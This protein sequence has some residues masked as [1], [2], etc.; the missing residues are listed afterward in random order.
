MVAKGSDG[1]H[2]HIYSFLKELLAKA[3]E[4]S[5]NETDSASLSRLAIALA[6]GILD[7]SRSLESAEDQERRSALSQLLDA[8]ESQL[9]STALTD[10]VHR[11]A[12]PSAAVRVLKDLLNRT[13]GGKN[14][15]AVDR[16]QLRAARMFGSVVPKLTQRA[17]IHR[18]VEEASPYLWS[19]R[20]DALAQSLS[21]AHARGLSV[22]L[23][24]LGEEVLGQ[25]EANARLEAYQSLASRS[26]IDA[27][28]LK[29]SAIE[30][31]LELRCLER[32]VAALYGRVGLVIEAGG[33]RKGGPPLLYFDMETYHDLPV[34][35]A[36]MERL[37]REAP[38]SARLGIAIQAYIPESLTAVRRL[39]AES[40]ERVKNGGVPL[41]IRLVKGAN[42][43]M[44]TVLASQ[45]RLAVPIFPA[46]DQVDAHFKRVLRKAACEAERGH[47]SLGVGSHNLFD[48]A[49]AILVREVISKNAVLEIEMLQGMAGTVGLV[50]SELTGRLLIYAPC[51]E[52][53]SFSSAVS[54]LVRRLDENTA[55]ENFM[56]D[57]P[58]LER[59]DTAY[60]IQERRFLDAVIESY[61]DPPITFRTQ[62]RATEAQAG[63]TAAPLT[64]PFENAADTDF[65]REVN[66]EYFARH[67]EALRSDDALRV[68]PLIC[69]ADSAGGRETTDGFDPSRPEARY[70]LVLAHQ[71]D[72]SR[73]ISIASEHSA[74]WLARRTKERAQILM[75]VADLLE[76][77]RGALVAAMVLD[78][79]KR[80]QEADIEVSEA[81]DFA[82]YYARQALELE[83]NLDPRGVTVVTPPWNFPLAIPLGGALAALV[84]GNTVILKPAPETPLVTYLAT[85]LCYDAGIPAEALSFVPCRDETAKQLIVDPRVRA[86]ILTGATET[87][88]LFRRM[89]PDLP[90]LAETG[91]KNGAYVAPVCDRELAI[92]ESVRSAFGH[93]GQKC[94]ALSFLVLHR[95][96]YE[97]E[98]FKKALVDAA[99]SLPVGSAWD[100]RSVVTPLINPPRGPLAQILKVGEEYG[101]WLLRPEVDRTNPRLLSPGILWDVKPGSFP[102]KA[103]FFG[104]VLSVLCAEDLK[105]ALLI[106]NSTSYGLTAGLFS[107]E[108]ADHEIFVNGI[109]AGNVYLNRGITGAVVARQPFGGHKASSF[110][111]GA[112]AGGPDYVRQMTVCR[113]SS[114]GGRKLLENREEDYDRAFDS[115][116]RDLIP[117]TEVVGEENYLRYLPGRTAVVFGPQA[118]PMDIRFAL[119]ARRLCRAD[120][121][122][123]VLAGKHAGRIGHILGT[124]RSSSITGEGAHLVARAK[125]LGVERLRVIGTPSSDL[126]KSAG[127]SDITVIADPVSDVGRQEL[128]LYL[129][130]QSVSHTFHRHG[131]TSLY[132]LSRLKAALV[133]FR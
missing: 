79:G 29:L 96:V 59:G 24:F 47:I 38:P 121:P 34:T 53:E 76:T 28:S 120:A 119:K 8:P 84:A 98:S 106:L 78:A 125:E 62:N 97:D 87:A 60:A 77:H 2:E 55:P 127:E 33:T 30:P 71:E 91:G 49:Y 117:G 93:S 46:K 20:N 114:L 43:Q 5:L 130:S 107:L 52:E 67:L 21:N 126:L 89:R 3:R 14:F 72:I 99:K 39:A 40:A 61:A 128:P 44:E 90:V 1:A 116:F 83:E 36:L 75:N 129:R 103:E 54:Y 68:E 6:G 104:P 57:A 95:E 101:K 112:K 11:S 9:F 122:L 85:K 27:L 92:V 51:V 132:A 86:V 102:Q 88:R 12:S 41:R 118:E 32:T 58:R 113:A 66:R 48:V 69:G 63:A 56:R 22:N 19:A 123:L 18:L 131:N 110:G 15:P 16:I 70:T 74:Y 42:L 73:A 7:A 17:L 81:V 4:L 108:E 31:H 115:H 25:K 64:E 94:S 35:V 82:R 50:V 124:E 105:E 133:T 65:T 100:P 45:H 10:R 26:D 13:G 80:V 111:P 109:E 23:N 37:L